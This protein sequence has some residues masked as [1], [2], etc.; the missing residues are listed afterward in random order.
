ME[1][2]LRYKNWVIGALILLFIGCI[3]IPFVN[4]ASKDLQDVRDFLTPIKPK[5]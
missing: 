1:L 3:G 4:Q 2:L 5:K